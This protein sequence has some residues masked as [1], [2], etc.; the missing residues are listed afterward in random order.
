MKYV[1][2]LTLAAALKS[3]PRG[4]ERR[5]LDSGARRSCFV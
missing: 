5:A 1:H 4:N 2:G 3:G